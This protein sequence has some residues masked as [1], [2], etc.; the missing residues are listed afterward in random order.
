MLIYLL[1]N[2]LL[3]CL[4]PIWLPWMLWRASRRKPMPDWNQRSGRYALPR[5]DQRIWFHAVSV[6][7]VIAAKPILQEIRRLA[8]DANL[9]VS[10]TTSSGFATAET[11][12]KDIV[13]HVIYFP[14]DF[15]RFQLSAMQQLRPKVAVLMETELWF[16]FLWAASVF[17]IPVILV[18]G[19]ISERS[20]KRMRALRPVFGQMI[21]WLSRAMMQSQGDADRIRAL[22][23]TRVE[24]V[25]N[26][27]FDE[28]DAPGGLRAEDWPAQL[29]NRPDRPVVVFGSIRAEE[30]DLTLGV[31]AQLLPIADVV[32]APRHLDRRDELTIALRR[33]FPN[34]TPGYRSQGDRLR[35]DAPLILDT[36]GELGS[37]YQIATV[38]VIGGGFAKLGGQNLIQPLAHGVPVVHGPHMFN[39]RS[40]TELA[41]AEGASFVATDPA[42]LLHEV[43]QLL[44]NPERHAAAARAARK[45][46]AENR[47]ASR[48]YAEA[49][50]EPIIGTMNR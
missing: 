33:A 49:I 46:V 11:Q 32:F 48:R 16:N 37:L 50:V 36:Y 22:G 26:S 19:R 18:N 30:F 35:P 15:A 14:I 25:G 10:V 45:I 21:A 7:E 1:Y 31:A 27:K 5:H 17:D 29:G 34:A 28:A 38:A 4:A 13:D 6:G 24:V 43:S 41:L 3:T 39:F 12:L 20:G 8:P 2:G 47:G 42:T 40:A 44:T 23:N 9:V